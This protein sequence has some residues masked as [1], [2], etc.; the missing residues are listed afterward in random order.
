MYAGLLDYVHSAFRVSYFFY[1]F[2]FEII[3][4]FCLFFF[5]WL[6]FFFQ[7]SRSWL[8]VSWHS[9]TPD[10]LFSLC[11]TPVFK[12]VPFIYLL[13]N[14]SAFKHFSRLHKFF[15]WNCVTLFSFW[16]NHN[17]FFSYNLTLLSFTEV[18]ANLLCWVWQN[19]DIS[20]TELF[21]I[22]LNI[23]LTFLSLHS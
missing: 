1:L 15:Q 5:P 9:S 17:H 22:I 10:S 11:S 4:F 21:A 14:Y 6:C 23:P 8:L 20:L 19:E 16:D 13:P 2:Y 12:M 7:R 3:L 18:G